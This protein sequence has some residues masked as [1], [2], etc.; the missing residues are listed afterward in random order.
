[1]HQQKS[2]FAAVL[3]FSLT[4]VLAAQ[5]SPLPADTST[6]DAPRTAVNQPDLTAQAEDAIVRGD[7]QQAM[8]LLNSSL[9]LQ[10]NNARA[11]YDRGY[12][13]EHLQ[14]AD[15]AIADFQKAIVAD[16][17]QYEAY[18]A[19]GRLDVDQGKLDDARKQLDAAVMLTPADSHPA[20]TKAAAFRLLAQVDEQLHDPA[21]A[22]DA[23]VAALKLT[24]EQPEDTLLAAR[25][26]EEQ[27]DTDTAETEY[28]KV[29]AVV[30]TNDPEFV[31]ATTGLTRQ[32]IHAGKFSDAEPLL[33]SA[34]VQQPQ[35]PALMAQLATVLVGEGKTADAISE[36]E[37]LHQANPSQPA[38][39]RM[40]ADLYTR[41][42]DPAKADPLYVQ[43]LA[44]GQPD[45][46]L[47]T[48]R[49]ENLIRQQRYAEAVTVL[50]KALALE[51]GQPDT[52]SDLAFAAS[53]NHQYDLVL[54]ALDHR[55]NYEPEV[56]AT[57]FLRATALDHLHQTKKAIAYYQQF[58]H[59]AQD[60]F[61]DEAW[62]AQHR[63]AAL[64]K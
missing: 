42:G 47:L 54:Q 20:Q 7:M 24:P 32:L 3:L 18:A 25:L 23:L 30:S 6:A 59:T 15:A 5:Q 28:R 45:A 36:L 22:T 55:A 40:L 21:A 19:L 27:G 64:T 35:N 14:H 56:P 51:P 49:G 4:G 48:A 16:P 61:P 8:T 10:P 26:A 2:L 9:A 62:Q 12:V 52:W 31:D 50:Q 17:K 53:E 38:V 46:D 41:T 1:M 34:L 11:L 43:L 13:E 57:L 39:T 60:K 63:L 37:T 29:L 58:L 33:R 44:Q